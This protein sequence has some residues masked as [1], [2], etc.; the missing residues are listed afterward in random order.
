[1]DASPRSTPSRSALRTLG[2]GILLLAVLFAVLLAVCFGL[3]AAVVHAIAFA[4]GATAPDLR[5]ITSL[6]VVPLAYG[7]SLLIWV[8]RMNLRAPDHP[9][10]V[11][12]TA[13]VMFIAGMI[14]FGLLLK[15][16]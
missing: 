5:W 4:I 6:F 15:R 8:P 11:R 16:L 10:L 3:T 1:M 13:E 2:E 9:L 14:G 12:R 7:L